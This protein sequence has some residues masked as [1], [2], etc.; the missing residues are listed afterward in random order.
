MVFLAAPL[1]ALGSHWARYGG[2]ALVLV[3][4]LVVVLLSHNR[5]SIV[6]IVIGLSA[7]GSSYLVGPGWHA[8]TQEVLG[9]G[10]IILTFLALSWVV[11]RAVFA[12]GR[13]TSRRLQGA[14]VLYLNIGVIFASA[15]R[16]IWELN[17]VAFGNLPPPTGI[18]G[19]IATMLYF[20]F[21]TL[22]STGYGDILP[23]DPFARSL[24][25][26]EA[27]V[28]QLY[29]ATALARLVTLELEDRRR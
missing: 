15:Y 24:A 26:L 9:R 21:V 3:F 16:L 14:I 6:A 4:V 18:P 1:S 29:L 13:I 22:T 7:T 28:G 17:P 27:V 8:A 5:A 2:E 10:G 19:E 20:S 12:P 25:N 11:S 23:V